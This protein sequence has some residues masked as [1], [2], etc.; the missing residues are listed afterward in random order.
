M[1]ALPSSTDKRVI[2]PNTNGIDAAATALSAGDLVAFPTE[3]VYGL[4]ADATNNTAVASIYSAKGRPTF[5]PL[6]VH[7]AHINFNARIRVK[8]QLNI[9]GSLAVAWLSLICKVRATDCGHQRAVNAAFKG[10]ENGYRNTD[11]HLF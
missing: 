8:E 5:N 9:H 10:Y 4:G 3:T 1:T 6:I 11:P 7:Q 2:K